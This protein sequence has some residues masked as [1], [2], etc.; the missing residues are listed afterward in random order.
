[1]KAKISTPV[2]WEEVKWIWPPTPDAPPPLHGRKLPSRGLQLLSFRQ[3]LISQWAKFS[4]WCRAMAVAS[5]HTRTPL[6]SM[7]GGRG[8][9]MKTIN[10]DKV[11]Q[12]NTAASPSLTAVTAA[13]CKTDHTNRYLNPPSLFVALSML[14]FL[15]EILG[16][17]SCFC[18]F[19]NNLRQTRCIAHRV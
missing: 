2:C 10:L 12:A 5:T 18:L 1:M 9:K 16:L 8:V 11:K 17:S 7:S 19:T 13:V 6:S 4:W 14:S 3:F 15:N